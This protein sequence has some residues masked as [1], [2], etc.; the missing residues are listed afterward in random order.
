MSL[1]LSSSE[2]ISASLRLSPKSPI[3]SRHIFLRACQYPL[4]V[5]R[6]EKGG[7]R[8]RSLSDPFSAPPSFTR[9]RLSSSSSSLIQMSSSPHA[10]R[11]TSS[12]SCESASASHSPKPT[13]SLM[14]NSRRSSEDKDAP[15]ETGATGERNQVRQ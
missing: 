7:T 12:Q 6:I 5:S 14:M 3:F 11:S 8:N 2:V 9:E 1:Y 13:L 15:D 10:S 4:R